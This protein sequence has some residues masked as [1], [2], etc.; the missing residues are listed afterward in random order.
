[1]SESDYDG[2]VVS[3][4]YGEQ[5]DPG[6]DLAARIEALEELAAQD[7]DDSYAFD[8][9]EQLAAASQQDGRTAAQHLAAVAAQTRQQVFQ[10][11]GLSPDAKP[12]P[13]SHGDVLQQAQEILA[14]AVPDYTE[15]QAEIAAYLTE[16]DVDLSPAIA[17]GDVTTISK[18]LISAATVAKIAK[19]DPEAK[20][21]AQTLSGSNSA[22]DS[23]TEWGKIAAANPNLKFRF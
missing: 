10:R 7:S 20:R 4:D 5:S 19:T 12:P 6:L 11:S 21:Q 18:A 14:A 22:R 15:H 8:S 13:A 9:P 1:M 16:T 17:A 3:D 23:I 2:F